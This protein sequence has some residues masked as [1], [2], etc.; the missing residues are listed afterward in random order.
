M[1]TTVWWMPPSPLLKSKGTQDQN[2]DLFLQWEECKS[3]SASSTRKRTKPFTLFFSF[4]DLEIKLQADFIYAAIQ[5]EAGWVFK[6]SQLIHARVIFPT[7][8]AFLLT[9][10]V[11]ALSAAFVQLITDVFSLRDILSTIFC[12]QFVNHKPITHS[13]QVSYLKR[14]RSLRFSCKN[15]V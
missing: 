13:V 4:L 2:W 7:G 5:I 12:R 3:R 9:E 6:H 11:G 14:L 1:D 8:C 10:R 15:E